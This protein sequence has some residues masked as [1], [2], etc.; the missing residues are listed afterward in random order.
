MEGITKVGGQY[1]FNVTIKMVRKSV[2]L[3]NCK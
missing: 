1:L 3:Q 2:H